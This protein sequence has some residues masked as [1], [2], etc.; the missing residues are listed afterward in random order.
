M[1]SPDS[2]LIPMVQESYDLC[3]GLSAH[4]NRFPRAQRGLLERV[5]DA[6]AMLVSLTVANRRPGCQRS[7][8]RADFLDDRVVHHGDSSGSAGTSSRGVTMSGVPSP[9]IVFTA[10]M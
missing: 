4:V 7:T 1:A 10:R 8:A 9:S 2:D 5:E 3:A 6:L